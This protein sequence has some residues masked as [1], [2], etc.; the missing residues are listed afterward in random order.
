MSAPLLP[1]L[2]VL[3]FGPIYVVGAAIVVGGLVALILGRAPTSGEPAAETATRGKADHPLIRELDRTIEAKIDFLL[4]MG[5]KDIDYLEEES[6]R[7]VHVFQAKN[8]MPL[9]GGSYL[10]HFV[11]RKVAGDVI[12]STAVLSFIGE[13]KHT[14]DIMKGILITTGAFSQSAWNVLERAPVE[15]IDGKH[16][17]SFFRMW[18]P[19]QFPADRI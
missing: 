17:L 9:S 18:H 3:G 10:V 13:V 5:F 16:L 12:P 6:R 8:P 2:A 15:L 4:H 19:D 7:D 14:D 1:L 11:N